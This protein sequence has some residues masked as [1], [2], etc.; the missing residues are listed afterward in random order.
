MEFAGICLGTQD[1][2]RLAAFY[3]AVL[4]AGSD[5]EGD[6]IHQ[7]ITTGG[8]ELAIMKEDSASPTAKGGNAHLTLMF[9]VDDVDAEHERLVAMG[10]EILSPPQLRPW[11]AKNMIFKDPDGNRVAFRS[12]PAQ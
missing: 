8:P 6:D 3:R 7:Q 2:L 10:V 1:V 11:G 9:T 4:R 5:D 12:F